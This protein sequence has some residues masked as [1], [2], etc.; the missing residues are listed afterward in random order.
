MKPGFGAPREHNQLYPEKYAICFVQ[1]VFLYFS[2][3]QGTF[4]GRRQHELMTPATF[5]PPDTAV[6]AHDLDDLFPNPWDWHLND[7]LNDP[8]R[9]AL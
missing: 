8:I 9:D 6:L 1:C 4:A 3:W 5:M 7:L 2:T